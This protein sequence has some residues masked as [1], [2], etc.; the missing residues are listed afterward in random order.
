[1]SAVVISTV[2]FSSYSILKYKYMVSVIRCGAFILTT[3]ASL[4]W[5][6]WTLRHCLD[7][8]FKTQN[9]PEC[10]ILPL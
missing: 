10:L 5:L 1:M 4:T 9:Q 8:N 7:G 3:L 2:L 6:T